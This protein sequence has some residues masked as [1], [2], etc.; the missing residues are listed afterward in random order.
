M[1]IT[2]SRFLSLGSAHLL[3]PEEA[4][5]MHISHHR[6]F[7]LSLGMGIPPT[8]DA[9]MK[10]TMQQGLDMGEEMILILPMFHKASRVPGSGNQDTLLL[11]QGTRT[12]LG[13]IQSL[14]PRRP[15]SQILFQPPVPHQCSQRVDPPRQWGLQLSP[16]PS[17]RKT[18]SNT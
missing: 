6:A 10:A 15:I 18:S 4:W 2:L 17:A 1:A 11:D 13:C 5:I 9:I 12:Q 14:V 16:L 8:K 7:K 3:Q